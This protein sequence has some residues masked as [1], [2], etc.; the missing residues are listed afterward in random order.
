MKYI[1][2]LA[3]LFAAVAATGIILHTL[4]RTDDTSLSD[5]PSENTT[6]SIPPVT[7]TTPSSTTIPTEP[8]S[9]L[10][11]NMLKYSSDLTPIPFIDFTLQ[12]IYGD[13]G[14]YAFGLPINFSLPDDDTTYIEISVTCG[15]FEDQDKDIHGGTHH[16]REDNGTYGQHF[17]LE[18][19]D[20][21]I[22]WVKY[23]TDPETG[24]KT[25][26]EAYDGE[27]T[28]WVDPE[29]GMVIHYVTDK[30][31]IDSI[32]VD[33]VFYQEDHVIA[34]AVVKIVPYYVGSG[35]YY[36]WLIESE[37]YPPT[38]GVYQDIS[39]EFIDQQII[40]AKS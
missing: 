22:Y 34:Y 21:T 17:I 20:R 16:P 2:V 9:E 32:Y 3:L 14:N 11:Q 18:D 26:Y 38:D 27:L 29:S 15:T 23:I 13:G 39:R 37:Y 25:T 5:S 4:L 31:I 24:H 6:H 28:D 30:E 12:N 40:K 33:A 10:Q 1:R 35:F 8:L 7:Q 36:S 19:T